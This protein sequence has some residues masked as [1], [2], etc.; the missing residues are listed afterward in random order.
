MHGNVRSPSGNLGG[1]LIYG[2]YPPSSNNLLSASP[3]YH[4]V[5]SPSSHSNQH[6]PLYVSSP[7]HVGLNQLNG[8]NYASESAMEQIQQ[9]DEVQKRVYS[10]NVSSPM[11]TAVD[12]QYGFNSPCYKRHSEVEV[13]NSVDVEQLLSQETQV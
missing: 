3:S 6:S 13:E 4:Q 8:F 2:L 12:S 9:F 1:N 10:Q 7:N 5:P 11:S